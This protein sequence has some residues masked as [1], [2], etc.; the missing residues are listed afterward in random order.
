MPERVEASGASASGIGAGFRIVWECVSYRIRNLEMANLAAAGSIAVAL[1]LHW[2]DIGIR[3]VFAF[4]LNVLVYLNNDYID[5]AVD[6][7]SADKDNEKTRFLHKHIRAAFWAQIALLLGLAAMA[8]V[9]DIGLLVPLIAGGGVCWWYSYQLK[10]CP[11]LDIVAMMIWGITMPLVGS[12]LLSVLG[13]CLALQ[14]GLFSGVFESIQVVRDAD[15]DSKEGVRTTAVVLGKSR[16]LWLA[17]AIMVTV[18]VYAGLV[19]HPIA[20]VITLAALFV[21]FVPDNVERY[22]T[23]VKL[24]YGIAWLFICAW[25]FFKGQSSGLL[26]AIERTAS[27]S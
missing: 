13:W 6:L 1:H 26:W 12:P 5:V 24:V 23:R 4:L 25:V 14:L 15:E 22:W 19:L 27:L 21:P 8:V 2:L 9:Y 7:Q 18:S 16:T 20:A 10:R 3:T 11:Y 17:R